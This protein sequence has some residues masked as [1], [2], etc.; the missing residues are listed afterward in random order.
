MTRKEKEAVL[1]SQ[2]ITALSRIE[3]NLGNERGRV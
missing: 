2:K 3:N 1:L